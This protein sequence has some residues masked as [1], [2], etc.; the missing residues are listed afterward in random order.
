MPKQ[1]FFAEYYYGARGGHGQRG[2]A[3]G[4]ILLLGVRASGSD[5]CVSAEK[6]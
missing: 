3:C 2:V 5:G 1:F 4:L 6:A